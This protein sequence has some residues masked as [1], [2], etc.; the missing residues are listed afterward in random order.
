MFVL[1]L[2]YQKSD[3]ALEDNFS[4]IS[5]DLFVNCLRR[6]VNSIAIQAISLGSTSYWNSGR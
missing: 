6:N 4:L 3:I 5:S 2:S 1:Y